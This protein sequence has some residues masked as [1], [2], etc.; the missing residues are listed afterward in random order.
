MRT[1][2]NGE[3]ESHS[4][5]VTEGAE[6]RFRL[7]ALCGRVA[8]PDAAEL[9]GTLRGGVDWGR[10]IKEATYH[11]VLSL[12]YSHLKPQEGSGVDDEALSRARSRVSS[13]AVHG[14][15]LAHELDRLVGLFNEAE[16]PVI[17]IKGV[18]LSKQAYGSIAL[19]PFVDSDLLIRPGDFYRLRELLE[20][21]G[22]QW[23]ELSPLQQRLYLWVHGQYTF[24]YRSPALSGATSI[25]DVHTAV[26]PFGYSYGE[27]FDDLWARTRSF[28]LGTND[29]RV[30][31]PEDLVLVLCY[32]G[33][34]NRWDRLKYITDISEVLRSSPEL[35]WDR[36]LERAGTMGSLRVL[37]LGALLG[38]DVLSAPV[39]EAVVAAA[40]RDPVVAE[41][42]GSIAERLPSEPYI[43][44][45]PLNVRVHLNMSGQ[46]SW[47]GRLRYSG[48]TVAR[49]LSELVLP[50]V[51]E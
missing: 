45:E 16:I 41:L 15:C 32:H 25:L 2:N 43:A 7:L 10:L 8:R 34:K 27:S 50:A 42:A 39:P 17:S 14:M 11:G 28:S 22:Y 20:R 49:R 33:F 9:E 48:Y 44:R 12:L 30:L 38:R 24:W 4:R 29:V 18:S 21:E 51:E 35:D 5:S 40:R 6:R 31:E 47:R 36:V 23:N 3:G 13:F 26:M 37:Y 1:S 46:D 19:R